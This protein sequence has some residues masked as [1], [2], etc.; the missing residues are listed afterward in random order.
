MSRLIR[1]IIPTKAGV[2]FLLAFGLTDGIAIAA[3]S[4]FSPL[5][6]PQVDSSS[7]VMIEFWPDVSDYYFVRIFFG[8]LVREKQ[9]AMRRRK[10]GIRPR[11]KGTK[12]DIEKGVFDLS[13]LL[14]F[15]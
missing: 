7:W 8:W 3:E 1:L 9:K 15:E 2:A 6:Y 11:S 5:P 14:L 4:K 10:A 12:Q 13:A